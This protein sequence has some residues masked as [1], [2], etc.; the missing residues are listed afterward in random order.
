VPSAPHLEIAASLL[1]FVGS[2]IMAVDLLGGRR[3]ALI[4]SGLQGTSESAQQAGAGH[5]ILAS[6]NTPAANADAIEVWAGGISRRAAC[7][8]IGLITVGFLCDLIS[9]LTT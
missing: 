8:G 2:L 6:D 9:K 3:R 5:T 4:K 1:N 7:W